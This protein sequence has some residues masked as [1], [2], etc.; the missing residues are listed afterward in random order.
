VKIR[1]IHQ[2]F[3]PDLSSTSQV[4]NQVAFYLAGKGDEVS[5]LCSRNRYDKKL[6]KALVFQGIHQGGFFAG[7][8]TI[9]H[10]PS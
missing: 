2:F 3:H 10:R 7:P 5:V 8:S 4:I 6:R 1:I 9:V